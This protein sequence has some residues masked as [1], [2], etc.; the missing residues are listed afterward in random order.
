MVRRERNRNTNAIATAI[1]QQGAAG[2][3]LYGLV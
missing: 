3:E 2:R 1:R